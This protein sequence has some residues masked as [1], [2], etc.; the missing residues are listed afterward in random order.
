MH[1]SKELLEKYHDGTCS[2]DE[3]KAVEDWLFNDAADENLTL[4][5]GEDKLALQNEMWN[6]I[7]SILP[8]K[9][10]NIQSKALVKPLWMRIA[11]SVALFVTVGSGWYFLGKTADPQHIIVMNNTSATVNKDVHSSDFTILVG[12]KSNVEINNETGVID[13]CGAMLINPKADLEFTIQGTCANPTDNIEKVSLKKGLKYV[14]LN[15]SVNA[16][17]NEVIILEEGSMM[18]LPPLVMKQ[19]LHQF[20]I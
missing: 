15:Y 2:A 4:R 8:E 13:F 1:I 11:A 16:T 20:N 10:E 6:N 5:A 17:S 18:S 14:A 12:P 19:L 3:Q 7:A 9:Q